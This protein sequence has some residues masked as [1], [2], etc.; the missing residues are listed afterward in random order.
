MAVT[1]GSGPQTVRKDASRRG[2]PQT[3]RRPAPFFFGVKA[4]FFFRR[5]RNGP[6]PCRAGTLR[7][8]SGPCKVG[9]CP[10]RAAPGRPYTGGWRAGSSRPTQGTVHGASGK[11]RP[12]NQSAAPCRAGTPADRRTKNG[13]LTPG[14]SRD[15]IQDT[16]KGRD[17]EEYPAAPNAERSRRVQGSRRAAEKAPGEP[18][19]GNA[20]PGPAVTG[21]KSAERQRSE[22]RWHHGLVRVRPEPKEAQGVFLSAP[23]E[24]MEL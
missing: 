23:V 4:R 2:L 3:N 7:R 20:P 14:T 1:A 9:P 19:G 16:A 10:P 21:I 13:N 22:F 8:D 5:K 15:R 12:T 17:R 18:R 11:P 6:C 24:K